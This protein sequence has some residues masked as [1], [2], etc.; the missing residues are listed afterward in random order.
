MNCDQYKDLIQEFHDGE[1]PRGNE[2]FLFTHL[3]SCGN[4]REFLKM[5]N[6]S[7]SEIK[8]ETAVFPSSLDKKVLRSA[9]AIE[10]RKSFLTRNI[11]AYV[12]YTLTLILIGFLFFSLSSSS[13]QKRELRQV[14]N[15]LNEQ[16]KLVDEQNKQ[17]QMLM[18]GLPEASVTSELENKI[19][20]NA[21]M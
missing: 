2:A 6:L 13:D 15:I 21:N 5:L 16:N 9:A 19:I 11:P 8:H 7:S 12:T 20:I 3:S 10:E 14:I 4:C 18:N 1:L 17:L